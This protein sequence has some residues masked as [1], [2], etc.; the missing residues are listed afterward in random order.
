M[1]KEVL[2][3][4]AGVIAVAAI[5]AVI[6]YQMDQKENGEE[7][8]SIFVDELNIGEIKTWFADKLEAENMKGV[9]LYPTKENTEKWKIKMPESDNMLIQIVYDEEA[10]TV[11]AY[12]EIGFSNLSP[13]L[14]ELIDANGGTVVLEK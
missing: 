2:F 9:I 10:D 13:K 3:G 6:K 12:S 4:A 11:T 1:I 8:E 7:I 14:K 5:I